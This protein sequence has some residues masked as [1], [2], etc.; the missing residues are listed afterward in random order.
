MNDKFK[1]VI[2]IFVSGPACEPPTL[3]T[4]ANICLRG[5]KFGEVTRI[6]FGHQSLIPILFT[7]LT[8]KAP[9]GYQRSIP[10]KKKAKRAQHDPLVQNEPN[11]SATNNQNSDENQRAETGTFLFFLH[12]Y[13]T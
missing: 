10:L 2:Q 8:P 9:F 13:F 3:D 1:Y 5:D 7:L 11:T 6:N 4:G 12:F